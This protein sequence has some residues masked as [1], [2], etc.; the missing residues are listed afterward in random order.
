MTRGTRLGTFDSNWGRSRLEDRIREATAALRG[1]ALAIATTAAAVREQLEVGVGCPDDDPACLEDAYA[2]L[3]R[4]KHR[5]RLASREITRLEAT[6]V[7][8]DGATPAGAPSMGWH[9]PSVGAAR[10][11]VDQASDVVTEAQRVA[12]TTLAE[13]GRQVPAEI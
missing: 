10:R 12:R 3:L 9:V 4:H 7:Q 5:V 6:T 2:D 8:Y 1:A 11:M 13:L